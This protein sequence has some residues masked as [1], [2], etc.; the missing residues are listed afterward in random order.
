M[1]FLAVRLF[2]D[3]VPWSPLVSVFVTPS[4]M[5]AP[6]CLDPVTEQMGLYCSDGSKTDL[7]NVFRASFL[8]L[9]FVN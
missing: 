9:G 6:V 1:V 4:S 5:A 8:S 3:L 2:R 7:G